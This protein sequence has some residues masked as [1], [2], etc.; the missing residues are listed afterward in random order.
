MGAIGVPVSI[1]QGAHDLMVPF[2]HGRWLAGQVAGAR[3][4]LIDDEGH[5]SLLSRFGEM[6]TEL[7][8]LAGLDG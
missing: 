1:W 4:H 2:A 6:L 7:R 3:V 5:V 8:E